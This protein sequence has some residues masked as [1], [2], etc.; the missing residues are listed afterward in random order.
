MIDHLAF[1][2][3]SWSLDFSLPRPSH[4]GLRTF[5]LVLL[6][7]SHPKKILYLKIIHNHRLCIS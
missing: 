1:S 6:C 3:H 5:G 7:I 2:R 4:V